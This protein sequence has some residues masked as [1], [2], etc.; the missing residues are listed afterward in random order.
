MEVLIN[1]RQE[2]LE[3]SKE[4]KQNIIKAIETCI[5][6]EKYNKDLEISISFVTNDEIKYLNK[7]FRGINKI[8]DV[9]SF[10]MDLDFI[11]EGENEILGDIIISTER[12][13][14]QALDYGHS[15]EREIIYL[16][17]HSIFH[18]FGYD[19]MIENDKIEMR[20]KE[21]KTIKILGIYK[22]ER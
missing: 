5:K 7:E 8:T 21:K 1:N 3:I 12:A 10:P 6:V 18:L 2:D 16:I 9:L 19:H 22:S 13:K 11:I 20:K 17:I 15:V 14:E 4:L